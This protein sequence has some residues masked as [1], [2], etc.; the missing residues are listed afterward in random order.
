MI[1]CNLTKPEAV[2]D[3][4]KKSYT[5]LSQTDAAQIANGILL[6]GKYSLAVYDSVQYRYPEDIDKL[7]K[8]LLIELNQIQMATEPVKKTKAVMA[9]LDEE[10]VEVKI[11]LICDINAAEKAL[12]DREDLKTLL[13]EIIKE[14][15]EFQYGPIDILWQWALDRTNWSTMSGGELTR[16][17]RL[18]SEFQDTSVGTEIGSTGAKKKAPKKVAPITSAPDADAEVAV[19]TEEEIPEA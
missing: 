13:G 7:A 16:R 9:A 3:Q 17:V 6:S 1:V 10:P 2:L 18:R 12:G 14:G 19:E 4:V 8:Q 5:Q 15:V 11:G